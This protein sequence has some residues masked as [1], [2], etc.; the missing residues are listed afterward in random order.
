MATLSSSFACLLTREIHSA[1][2]AESCTISP[3]SYKTGNL[4]RLS[5]RHYRIFDGDFFSLLLIFVCQIHVSTQFQWAYGQSE[6]LSGVDKFPVINWPHDH[7]LR[8]ENCWWGREIPGC[9]VSLQES[10]LLFS[11]WWHK[12][13]ATV[14]GHD[15][16][17]HVPILT[18]LHDVRPCRKRYRK[19]QFHICFFFFRCHSLGK[20]GS[21]LSELLRMD[22]SLFTSILVN[23]LWKHWRRKFTHQV[24]NGNQP[25][26]KDL[27]M[28]RSGYRRTEIRKCLAECVPLG[29]LVGRSVV[30]LALTPAGFDQL[31]HCKQTAV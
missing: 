18:E 19:G 31:L 1:I 25:K 27:Q 9:S 13:S 26:S 29:R 8:I 22:S 15:Q 10:A 12:L 11:S 16:E 28:I 7:F 30:K 20:S 14:C 5:R 23:P 2:T 17:R 6:L 21:T 4:W 24:S 3:T